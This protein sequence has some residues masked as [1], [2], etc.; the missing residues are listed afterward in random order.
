MGEVPRQKKLK[1][2][3]M[4]RLSITLKIGFR[5]IKVSLEILWHENLPLQT[6]P[7]AL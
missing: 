7:T 2:H 5:L 1:Y 4:A 3:G 6:P